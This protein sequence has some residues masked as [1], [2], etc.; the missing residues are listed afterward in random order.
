MIF[1]YLEKE[2]CLTCNKHFLTYSMTEFNEWSNN[3]G[4]KKGYYLGIKY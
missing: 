3:D 2:K 1:L 4:W